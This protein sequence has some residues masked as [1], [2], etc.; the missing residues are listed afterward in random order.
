V[1]LTACQWAGWFELLGFAVPK[2]AS[3]E[4]IEK[5]VS[6]GEFGIRNTSQ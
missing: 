3:L 4:A 2:G 1:V 5:A 6:R